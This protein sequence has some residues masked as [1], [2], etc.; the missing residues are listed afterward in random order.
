M[1][2]NM[3]ETQL[4]RQ[5]TQILTPEEGKA[6]L[7]EA[8]DRAEAYFKDADKMTTAAILELEYIRISGLYTFAYES[9][10]NCIHTFVED[11]GIGRSS[12]LKWLKLVRLW[13]GGLHLDDKILLELG[14]GVR[15]IEPLFEGDNKMVGAY[16]AT[17]GEIKTIANG[18]ADK[19]PAGDTPEERIRPWVVEN[20]INNEGQTTV[21]VRN[22]LRAEGVTKD[23]YSFGLCDVENGRPTSL[24]WTFERADGTYK[25]GKGFKTMPQEVL[26]QFCSQNKIPNDWGF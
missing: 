2:I 18:W 17:T 8:L 23:T 7:A 22:R 5:D 13:T 3:E 25:E 4:T 20:I 6:M 16:N 9:W 26:R 12:T 15:T 11:R 14:D 21:I 1:E 24:S 10:N 19:L